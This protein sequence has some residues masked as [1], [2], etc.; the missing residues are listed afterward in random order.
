MNAEVS[1]R[2]AELLVSLRSRDLAR[3][4]LPGKAERLSGPRVRATLGM[5]RSRGKLARREDAL[6]DIWSSKA[7]SRL[8]NGAV[9]L[10]PR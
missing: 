1:G 7:D 10:H 9:S 8:K 5:S 4:F 2:L 6:R 3:W